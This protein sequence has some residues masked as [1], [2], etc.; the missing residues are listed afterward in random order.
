M[1]TND[2]TAAR[3]F[4]NVSLFPAGAPGFIERRLREAL[5]KAGFVIYEADENEWVLGLGEPPPEELT[6]LA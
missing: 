5:E 2:D 3:P 1:S 4:A 6:A